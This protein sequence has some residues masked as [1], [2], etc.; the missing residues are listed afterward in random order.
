MNEK[1]SY[2]ELLQKNKQLEKE[3]DR[4]KT[5]LNSIGDAVIST[6]MEGNISRMNPVAEKLTGWKR[7]E[8]IG[9]SIEEVF[10]I[11][12]VDTREKVENPVSKVLEQGEIVG[13]ANHTVLISKDG[14]EYQISDSGAPIKDDN[15]NI[16]G[17]VL[18]FRDVTEE[19]QLREELKQSEQK[20]RT[21]FENT[22]TATIIIEKDTTISLAN[23]EFTRLYGLPKEE[24]EDEISWTEFVADEDLERMKRYHRARRE[25]GKNAP[26]QYEFKMIDIEGEE[27]DIF[28][29]IDM[30]PE[31][32]QTVA[33][34]L[35]ITERKQM[36]KELRERE[37]QLKTLINSTPDIISFKDSEG[38]WLLANESNLELWSLEDIDY[39]G[40]TD[41]ELAEYTDPLYQDDFLTRR[42]REQKVWEN[43][44]ITRYEKNIPQKEG[45]DKTFDIIKVPIYK[46]SGEKQ[47]I[48][49]LGRNITERKQMEEGLK[50]SEQKYKR[51]VETTG[52]IIFVHD[53][54]GFIQFANQSALD[55]T[56]YNKEDVIGRNIKD[57]I[58]EEE[59]SALIKRK[60]KRQNQKDKSRYKFE[61][62]FLNKDGERIEVNVQATPLWE[63]N[64]YQGSLFVAR[65][66]TERKQ[67]QK[68]KEKLQE[69]LYQNQK[70]Q[71]IGTLAGGVAHDFNNLLT[72]IL[73]MSDLAMKQSNNAGVKS[74]IKEVIESGKKA[75]ELTDQLLLF[76]REKETE[77]ELINLNNTIQA[78]EKMLKRLIGEDITIYNEFEDNLWKMRGD[79]GQIEQII[80]NMAINA[81]DAMPEGGDLYISTQNITLDKEKAETIPDIQSGSYVRL[82]IEDTGEGMDEETQE[83]IFDPFFTT[84]GM[85]E[86]TGMGLSVVHGIVKN[87]DG[88]INV[89][90]EPG[91]G[92]VFRIYFPA[93]GKQEEIQ[94]K[95]EQ[96]EKN[97]DEY[98]GQGETIL[99]VEDEH[100]VLK[101]IENILRN[102]N[103]SFYS[104]QSAEESLDIF[105]DKQEEI[106]L[107]LSD[108]ILPGINGLELAEK[109]KKEKPNLNI[110]LNSGYSN[111][112]I[113]SAKVQN[114]GY[115]FVRKPFDIGKLLQSIYESI[116]VGL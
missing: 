3:K 18:V 55:Y 39:K 82:E 112:K 109:L 74:N 11:V 17:V 13:L 101:Y 32:K 69:Q 83:Q 56:G 5:T 90:S 16:T 95:S 93:I 57:F 86:G 89:Y 70:L 4:L 15:G 29:V 40:K 110:I 104:A 64:E 80:T 47:G 27:H 14:E 62:A 76:S 88:L 54:N 77:F 79:E 28:I 53:Q 23:K 63:T 72:V 31:T 51:L 67:A 65:D 44:G 12:N 42:E 105:E 106:E 45:P 2:E 115:K 66:I 46:E 10:N 19:Y 6:D 1:P 75:A 24:V 71:S 41:K 87:H 43:Q 36:E 26:N 33:S 20:Y 97:L 108:M 61:S 94:Q 96:E 60:N 85:A 35:D 103:Y 8:A 73:G 81:R 68:E 92:T 100:S 107:L 49:A 99:I 91:E 113:S 21:V 7:E 48:V 34:F 22:G 58:P 38:R 102:F 78:L 114:K 30:I 116:N 50:Q 98:R 52:D 111:N 84:K 9:Q 25:K 37:K 59:M